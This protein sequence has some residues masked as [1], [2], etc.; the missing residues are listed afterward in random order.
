MKAK[1][2]ALLVRFGLWLAS[3]G[4]WAPCQRSHIP[5]HATIDYARAVT[6]AIDD[7]M[8]TSAP[9]VK[10]REALRVLLNYYPQHRERD[11]NLLI[12]LALQ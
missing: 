9:E 8:S 10:R 7:T 3:L 11:L 4:G 6:Q 2:F 12:E 5:E 1:F